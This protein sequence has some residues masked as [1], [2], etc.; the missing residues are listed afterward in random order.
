[1]KNAHH[2]T[3][4]RA[5]FV[6]VYG[7]GTGDGRRN[8]RLSR[9]HLDFGSLDLCLFQLRAQLLRPLF[10][11]SE[12]GFK[13]LNLRQCRRILSPGEGEKTSVLLL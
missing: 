9:L 6:C 4:T 2:Q 7:M 8:L 3:K 10:S 5:G 12:T 13:L 11:G 1:M